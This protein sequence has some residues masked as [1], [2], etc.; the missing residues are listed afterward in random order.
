[1]ADL[2]ALVELI[3]LIGFLG[4]F[5]ILLGGLAVL[6]DYRGW[7]SAFPVPRKESGRHM[8]PDKIDPRDPWVIFVRRGTAL[9]ICVIGV[10][11]IIIGSIRLAD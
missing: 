1:M 11:W 6:F 5:V 4:G 3:D 10:G 9:G 7:Q 8:S 2:I